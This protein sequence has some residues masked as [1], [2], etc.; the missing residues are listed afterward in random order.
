MNKYFLALLATVIS[1]L[2]LIS[3]GGSSSEDSATVANAYNGA[4]SQWD[5]SLSTD[6]TF[7]ITH[8]PSVSTAIDMT[9]NGTYTTLTS[10]FLK[11]TIT[12]VSGT[13]TDKPS[14]GDTGYGLEIK[15][16][17]FF[18][19]PTDSTGEIITM[20][21]SGSCPTTD[22]TGNWITAKNLHDI[23]ATTGLGTSADV[24]SNTQ[25]GFGTFSWDNSTST[26]SLPTTYALA[27]P[28]AA[29]PTA[30]FSST[31]TCTDGI[32]DLSGIATMYL[33]SNGGAIVHN[34]STNSNGTTDESVITV[35][36]AETLTAAS[37]FDGDYAGVLIN[38]DTSS[39]DAVQ[40]IS[41]NCSSGT[42]TGSVIDPE[43]NA[44]PTSGSGTAT[45]DLTGTIN[46]PSAG[47]I[48]GTITISSA[49]GNITCM[50]D[51][52]AASTTKTLISCSGQEPG[53]NTKLF[54]V[55]LVSK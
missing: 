3:C 55:L 25:D 15:G 53:D 20:V 46:S 45:L 14:V 18:L 8:K 28:T 23:S 51:T 37:D 11:L 4:G 22:L 32:A 7:L 42:C 19:Q 17:A 50:V 33:T 26:L 48:N 1:S 38:S 16:Y 43:T 6:N 40:A 21:Q 9:I 35:F 12:S 2:L 29:F 24:S 5:I 36:A 13:S 30:G 47:F 31:I 27:A 10:G 54:N 34:E 44:A 41:V 49:S 52:N 39:S